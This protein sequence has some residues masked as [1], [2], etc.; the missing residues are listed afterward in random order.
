VTP[1]Y[2]YNPL[3]LS[4]INNQ[5]IGGIS[6]SDED[7]LKFDGQN[8]SLLF[9]GSDAGVGGSDLFAFSI[10]DADTILMSFSSTVTVNGVSAAPQD[11]LRFDASSLGSVTSGTFSLH[12]DGSDVGL[13]T[14]SENIDSLSLL[15]D[16]RLLMSTT[17]N[18]S[19]PNLTT[20][21]DEDVLAFTP[22][23]LGDGTSGSWSLYFDGSDVG[24]GETND[25]DVDALDVNSNG[26][27][28]LSTLGNFL[29]AGVSGA[30]EDV[31]IC[32]PT[33]TGDVTACNYST[34]LYFDGSTWGL[35]SNDV[36]AF[37]LLA[38]GPI[39]THTSTATPPQTAT[40]TAMP[41]NT[42]GPSSTA[43][44]T[45]APTSPVEPSPT[46]TPTA[47]DMAAPTSTLTATPFPTGTMSQTVTATQAGSL[48]TFTPIADAYVNASSPASNY[49]SS[50]TLRADA[51][52]DVRSYLRFDI[53]GLNGPVT[54]ATLRI[55]ANS[56]A[57]LGC[58]VSNVSDNTWIESTIN[59][60]NAPQMGDM[61][62][63]SGSFGAGVWI[64]LDITAYVT[65]DG[66]YNLGLT[67]P[68]STAISFASRESGAN[69]PQLTI[70]TAP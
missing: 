40:F 25:E 18:P 55:F 19:V 22:T 33:S 42:A 35:S 62:G 9:D 52:P 49:G 16:G 21:R 2:S 57:S 12:F 5:T 45:P 4:L 10:V 26:D 44:D 56:A 13:S 23:S 37:N 39:P 53:Q 48:F 43:T 63:S 6:A 3:Y 69:A 64:D 20:G 17:G 1:P 32:V 14:S 59:Y 51:S 58:T 46:F 8:W 47:T 7:I 65:G 70:E 50:T 30:D 41:T 54:R 36:D 60:S 67:T 38:S 29:V 34:A 66:T 11:V 31:F 27:I 15:P 68:G 28:Y 24:L 61:L